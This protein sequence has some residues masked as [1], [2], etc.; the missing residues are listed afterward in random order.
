MELELRAE[1]IAEEYLNKYKYD[2]FT[3]ERVYKLVKI[4]DTPIEPDRILIK[5]RINRI[6]QEC[7]FDLIK[8]KRADNLAQNPS[9]VRL[10]L[11]DEIEKIA[12][13]IVNENCFTLKS[14]AIKGDDLIANGFKQ[15][16]EV[17]FILNM[18]L[19]E[20][21]EEKLPNEKIALL[22]RAKKIQI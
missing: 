6:G 17:G 9:K 21:I 20:V 7:F 11:I 16:K 15:G 2:N 1:E 14:L 13:D 8:I 3:K 18:L 19:N 10:D 4:H 22:N 5:K 12:M